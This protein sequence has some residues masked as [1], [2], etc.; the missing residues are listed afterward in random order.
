M[1][2]SASEGDGDGD[3]IAEPH[4]TRTTQNKIR[5]QS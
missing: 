4:N 1:P 2:E 5:A 3:K